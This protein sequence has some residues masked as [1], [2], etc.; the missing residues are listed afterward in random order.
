MPNFTD[1]ERELLQQ[2]ITDPDSNI[3]AI[4]GLQGIVGSAFARYSRAPGSFR[5][6]LLKEFLKEGVIDPEHAKKLIERIL[7]A[8]GD[9]SVGELE[10]ANVSFEQVS[11][12][13]TKTI[14]FYQLFLNLFHL[15]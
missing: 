3:F 11:N 4:K 12:L 13:A 10:G 5:E 14:D 9:D 1:K 15:R 7:I 6:T 8:F 2:Y